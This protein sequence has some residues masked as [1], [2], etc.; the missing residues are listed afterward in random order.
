MLVALSPDSTARA[1]LNLPPPPRLVAADGGEQ[2]GV[3][4]IGRVEGEAEDG[5]PVALLQAA[6]VARARAWA[7]R[8]RRCASA[9]GQRAAGLPAAA[10]RL[11]RPARNTAPAQAV[12]VRALTC[13]CTRIWAA[14]WRGWG[15]VAAFPRPLPIWPP[16]RASCLCGHREAVAT[17]RQSLCI[18][19]PKGSRLRVRAP[20]GRALCCA[21]FAQPGLRPA[22]L[23][24]A[25][26]SHRFTPLTALIAHTAYTP[27]PALKS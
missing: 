7:G 17:V 8:G 13:W 2:V 18:A 12:R 20:R 3:G 14:P 25:R 24:S 9:A 11:R 15:R 16:R 19:P 21:R 26:R 5:A 27:P 10:Y 4:W 6:G 1:R 22:T 23:A